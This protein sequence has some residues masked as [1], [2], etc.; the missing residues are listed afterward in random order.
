MSKRAPGVKSSY[1]VKVLEKPVP[2]ITAAVP[3]NPY[4]PVTATPT[5]TTSTATWKSRLPASRR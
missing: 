2:L 1:C 3:L 4:S 5:S